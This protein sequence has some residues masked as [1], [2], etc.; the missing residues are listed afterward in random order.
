MTVRYFTTIFLLVASCVYAHGH[1]HGE[2]FEEHK[3]ET[4]DGILRLS[5]EQ[6]ENAGIEIQEAEQGVIKKTLTL[7]GRIN[8]DPTKYAYVITKAGGIVTSVR[9]QLGESVLA[10]EVL[11]TIDSKEMAQAKSDFLAALRRQNLA[12]IILEKEK[13]LHEKRISAEQEFL[14]AQADAEEASIEFELSRQKLYT[15][16]FNDA[17]IQ[18]LP[19]QPATSLQTYEI[20][21]PFD[22]V[23]EE[24]N[25][26]NGQ[27]VDESTDAFHVA[28]LSTVIV[29]LGV[30]PCDLGTIRKGQPVELETDDGKIV[31]S[32]I[33]RASRTLDIDTGCITAVASINNKSGI[34]FPGS[35]VTARLITAVEKAQ[36]VV[37][38]DAV[39]SIDN[40]NYLFVASDEGFEKREVG[41]G[42]ND[43]KNVAIASGLNPGEKYIAKNAIIVKF[44]LTKGEEE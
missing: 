19:N 25:L 24:C 10:G 31:R 3:E 9:K 17:E 26:V 36:V 23:V 22:G 16:G 43:D 7:Y 8:V 2:S 40:H 29:E 6:I 42:L 35:W 37:P 20:R 5:H 21:S 44:E 27:A 15:L 1:H 32:R 41:L 13:I 12:R 30:Y 11:A 14:Q 4:S 18:N 34:W 33:D 39:V 28:N 38:K